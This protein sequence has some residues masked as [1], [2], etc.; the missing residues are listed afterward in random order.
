MKSEDYSIPEKIR[1]Y[2]N[3]WVLSKIYHILNKA[4]LNLVFITKPIYSNN[5]SQIEIH[6]LLCKRDIPIYF[7]AIKSFVIF[8]KL[9][10]KIII[11][12]DGSLD[13]NCRKRIQ[14]HIINSN[15]ITR[16]TADNLINNK[17]KKYKSILYSREN[18]ILLL[19]LIDVDFFSKNGAKIILLDSD[20][21]FRRPPTEIMEWCRSDS[22]KI[23]YTQE[24]NYWVVSKDGIPF[25]LRK[26]FNWLNVNLPNTFNAGLLCYK[27]GVIDYDLLEKY[28]KIT[29]GWDNSFWAE[30]SF[31][32]II[33]GLYKSS[34]LPI[35]YLNKHKFKI[36]NPISRHHYDSK[37]RFNY[38]YFTKDLLRIYSK[39]LFKIK[40]E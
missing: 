1:Y 35:E 4:L 26:E 18:Y 12:D 32:A 2:T 24:P 17:L 20:I 33:C 7:N 28:C 10:P 38:F 36:K 3:K 8:S 19:K 13:I 23:L 31:Y 15:I 14:K 37:T 6:T 21:F 5:N 25:Y 11:H 39:L 29:R 22:S 30:Q 34:A 9:N 40:Y 27:K 16:K